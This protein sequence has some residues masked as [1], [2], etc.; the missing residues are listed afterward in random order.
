V[1][2]STLVQAELLLPYEIDA[3]LAA[4]SVV[5]LPLGSIEYHS[6][7]LPVGLDGLNAHGICTRVAQERGGI[8]LP[9][10]Y[11]GTG[12]GH[13]TYPWTIMATTQQPLVEL[14]E[15]SLTRLAQFGVRIAVLFTGHFADEQLGMI[16]DLAK[17]WNEGG[18][19]LK[20]LPLSVSQTSA[21]LAPDHAGVFETTLLAALWPD[22]VQLDQLPSITDAPT[23]DPPGSVGYDHRHHPE[24]PL[25]G[26]MGPDPRGSDLAD[27][28]SLLEHVVAWTSEQVERFSNR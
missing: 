18:S 8:V 20:V 5:Y 22:R 28:N 13:T 25:W 17:S 27:A 21:V 23:G 16:D 7:H 14:L 19:A 12:G 3:A 1:N 11:Y 2:P 10:L 26:V 24:H 6:R 4:N 15:T 9:T